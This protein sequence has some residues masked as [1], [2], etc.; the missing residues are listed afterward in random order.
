MD[1]CRYEGGALYLEWWM[2]GC[3]VDGAKEGVM[4]AKELYVGVEEGAQRGAKA[5]GKG[6]AVRG[7]SIYVVPDLQTD[8]SGP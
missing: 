3:G 2:N 5:G 8:T 7:C 4:F 1:V 6:G